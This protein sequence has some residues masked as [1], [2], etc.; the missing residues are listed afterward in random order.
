MTDK[1][2]ELWNNILN[3]LNKLPGY[4]VMIVNSDI[5]L[6]DIMKNGTLLTRTDSLGEVYES[7]SDYLKF[8]SAREDYILFESFKNFV[9]KVKNVR[10]DSTRKEILLKLLC[11][12]LECLK[13]NPDSKIIQAYL[14]II[15]GYL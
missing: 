15:Q 12:C 10:M 4:G 9:V 3:I 5:P 6:Y 11:A 7:L 13:D 14:D 8:E 2:S 1:H